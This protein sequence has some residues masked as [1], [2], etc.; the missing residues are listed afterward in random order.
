MTDVSEM[1]SLT[2]AQA[3]SDLNAATV[4]S[5]TQIQSMWD[6]LV[7]GGPVMIPIVLCSLVALTV[8][9]ERLVSLRKSLIIPANF[10]TGLQSALGSAG[11]ARQALESCKARPSPVARVFAA[12]LKRLNE[13]MELMEK[14]IQDAGEREAMKMRKYLRV[15]AVIASLA[16]LLGLLGTIAG[17]IKAFQTV[18]ASAE[19]LGKTEMLATGIYEAMITTAAG[20][21]VAIPAMVCYHWLTSR[22]DRLVM[23]ID[24]MTVDFVEEF[25]QTTKP[26]VAPSRNGESTRA[27]ASES[28][29]LNVP[30][31]PAVAS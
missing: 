15:L 17:M 10:L 16:P 23:D 26:R 6:F 27:H 9:V 28:L 31:V 12:G 30:S 1:V 21:V 11:G 8:V 18:A 20:L 14:H 19:A 5:A 2:I 4:S 29:E 25:S 7:K 13:P 24:Q 22:I 3:G